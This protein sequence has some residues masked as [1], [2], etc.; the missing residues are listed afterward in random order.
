M[1]GAPCQ[2][3]P[4]A[5]PEWKNNEELWNLLNQGGITNFIEKIQGHD[6]SI[7][8]QFV[9][10]WKDRKVEYGGQKVLINEELI[11]EAIGLGMDGYRFFNKRIDRPAEER[12]FVE[13]NEKLVFVTM[14]LQVSFI[15]PPFNEVTRMMVRY[16]SLEGRFVIVPLKH[17]VFLNHFH[18][19]YTVCLPHYLLNSLERSFLEFQ[20]HARAVPLHQG[21]I[22]LLHKLCLL[23]LPGILASPIYVPSFPT[24]ATDTTPSIPITAAATPLPS[25]LAPPVIPPPLPPPLSP[26]PR[27]CL[28]LDH[29]K[30]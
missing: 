29:L 2:I 25:F 10:D 13:G 5:D 18:R 19:N 28:E 22:F 20:K 27:T 26:P 24:T 1:G 30:G 3:E 15:P 8:I 7:S 9:K 6:K 17:L 23:K 11:A 14:G 4:S 12:K 16:I 21:L